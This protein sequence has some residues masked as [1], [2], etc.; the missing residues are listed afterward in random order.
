MDFNNGASDMCKYF[1][2]TSNFKLRS[3]YSIHMKI[4]NTYLIKR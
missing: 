1:P 2:V 4:Y 3:S